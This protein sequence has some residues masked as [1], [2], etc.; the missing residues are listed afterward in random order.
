MK[1]VEASLEKADDS[2]GCKGSSGKRTGIGCGGSDPL[3]A[4]D[5]T[6][7]PLASLKLE[8]SAD[9]NGS[10]SLN[11]TGSSEVDGLDGER[12]AGSGTDA[13]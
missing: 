1:A 3:I 4:S 5:S 8:R 9:G 10:D 2:S 6:V 7:D 13:D 12:S 11:E